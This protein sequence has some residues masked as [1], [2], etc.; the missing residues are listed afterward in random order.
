MT[1]TNTAALAVAAFLVG[2]ASPPPAKQPFPAARLVTGNAVPSEPHATSSAVSAAD[3][4]DPQAYARRFPSPASC[5]EAARAAIAVSRDQAWRVLSACVRRGHF[6]PLPRLLDGTWD[7]DLRTRADASNMLL[8]I[9][10]ARGGDVERDLRLLGQRHLA[11]YPLS[12][13]VAQPEAYRGRLVLLRVS[14]HEASAADGPVEVRV[15][16]LASVQGTSASWD[17]RRQFTTREYTATERQLIVRLS[18]PD[19]NLEPGR[20]LVLLGR[21]DGLR[22]PTEVEEKIPIV[23]IL[24]YATPE[25]RHID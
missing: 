16:Q 11:V 12:T 5:E 7:E 17:R 23:T 4:A 22:A 19:P 13:A 24:G 8:K 9:V 18:R 25:L 2:C 3:L 1:R 21:F 14:I 6:T 20:E 10:A 15:F